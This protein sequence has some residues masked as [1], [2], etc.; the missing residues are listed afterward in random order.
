MNTKSL[1]F[2]SWAQGSPGKATPHIAVKIT[3][4]LS[5]TSAPSSPPPLPYLGAKGW[6]LLRDGDEMSLDGV[7]C[8]ECCDSWVLGVESVE[9][10]ESVEMEL[11]ECCDSMFFDVFRCLD[12]LEPSCTSGL[13]VFLTDVCLLG[14]LAQ[15]RRIFS[16]LTDRNSGSRNQ[17]MMLFWV[18]TAFKS[19]GH[20]A[21][22][23]APV[24]LLTCFH[25]CFHILQ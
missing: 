22:T 20:L 7:R 18:K 17:G 23:D 5:K 12:L 9:S 10:V 15:R 13:A 6:Q 8:D 1:N 14:S 11:N 3:K 16:T 21:K 24:G 4:L 19:S 25:T 2:V